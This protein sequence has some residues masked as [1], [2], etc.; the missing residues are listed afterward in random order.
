MN[1]KQT[2][3]ILSRM[4]DRLDKAINKATLENDIHSDGPALD[5]KISRLLYITSA[6]NLYEPRVEIEPAGPQT[7]ILDSREISENDI[8]KLI[9]KTWSENPDTL[10]PT[11]MA[12][13]AGDGLILTQFFSSTKTDGSLIKVSYQFAR[14]GDY[15]E[16]SFGETGVWRFEFREIDTSKKI[17]LLDNQFI[18]VSSGNIVTYYKIS[19]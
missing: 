18:D 6:A 19:I 16:E 10:V 12:K 7:R 2:G 1:T 8:S 9:Y 13:H 15:E 5:A 17:E 4:T 3:C 11:Y 14:K